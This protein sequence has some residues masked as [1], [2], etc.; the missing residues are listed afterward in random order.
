MCHTRLMA[1][2]N[3]LAEDTADRIGTIAERAS[4]VTRGVALLTT[5]S[6]GLAYLVGVLVL[7]YPWRWLWAGLGAVACL[8]PAIA[9]W[10]ADRRLRRIDPDLDDIADELALMLGDRDVRDQL[11]DLV[12]HDDNH[13]RDAPLVELG[14]EFVPLR[15]A[16]A[17]HRDD[18]PRAWTS[19]NAITGQSGLI[20]LGIVG[21]FG[22]LIFSLVAVLASLAL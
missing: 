15:D 22:A 20:A 1:D 19:V 3:A 18:A 2:L 14:R 21:S 4:S 5:A 17:S 11:F 16:L 6:V 8:T 7:P 9:V 12:E 13:D 10:T